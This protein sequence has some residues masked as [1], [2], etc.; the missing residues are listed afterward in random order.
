MAKKQP[1]GM[2]KKSIYFIIIG[3]LFTSSAVFSQDSIPAQTN[4][5]EKKL[6]QFQEYFFKAL[7]QKAIENYQIA[8]QNL[9]LCNEMSPNDIS[10]LFELSKNHFQLNQRIEAIAY[11]KQAIKIDSENHWVLEHIVK[12]YKKD[13]NFKEAIKIQKN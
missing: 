1:W 6:L 9:E 4:V 7:A 11:A 10:V 5:K 8:I 12:V 2:C 13:R 3:F